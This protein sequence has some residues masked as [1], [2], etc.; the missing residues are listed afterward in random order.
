MGKRDFFKKKGFVVSS[1]QTNAHRQVLVDRAP[2]SGVARTPQPSPS[3]PAG[4]DIPADID[5][6]GTTFDWEDEVP[7]LGSQS[8][9]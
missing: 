7:A 4:F 8:K 6:V 9:V 1:T 2:M 3:R 5:P